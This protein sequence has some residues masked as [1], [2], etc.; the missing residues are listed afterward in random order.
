MGPERGLRVY[1]DVKRL[2]RDYPGPM[3]EV[4]KRTGATE[5]DLLFLAGWAG[6][7]RKAQRPDDDLCQAGAASC[8]PAT[9]RGTE[10]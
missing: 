7:A 8:R 9:A 6:G 5:E 2:E 10:I 3:A 4:R 1:D